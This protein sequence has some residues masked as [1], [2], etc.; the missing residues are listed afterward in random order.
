MSERRAAVWDRL[1][2]AYGLR[3]PYHPRKW[4]VIELLA[5]K[6][7]A[8]WSRSRIVERRGLRFDL[9]LR[10]LIPRDIYYLGEYERWESRYLRRLVKPGWVVADVGAN[11]GYYSLLF[12]KL[13][14]SSGCV[15]A[16][17]PTESTYRS[18]IRNV[19]LNQTTNVRAYRLALSD[20][21]GNTRLVRSDRNPALNRL[22]RPDESGEED[23]RVT[24]LDT[25]VAQHGIRRLDLIKIDIEGAEKD[26]LKGAE[27]TLVRFCPTLMIE[28]NTAALGRFGTSP[29]ALR[30]EMERMGYALHRP[31]WRGCTP[32]DRLPASNEYFNVVAVP[33]R[34]QPRILERLSS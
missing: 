26:F 27:S 32:L 1:L 21:A 25:F 6:A 30:G 28:L 19:T 14:G 20:R 33:R 10:Y 3:L 22:A 11:I 2:L 12:G 4:R 8:T 23:V 9:D 13:V 5:P 7:A 15:H 34:S 29:A 31:T 17:E 18:L 24:T 16:F